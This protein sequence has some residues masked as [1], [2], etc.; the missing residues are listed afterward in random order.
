MSARR[1]YSVPIRRRVDEIIKRID[2]GIW[3]SFIH[4]IRAPTP[5]S[6]KCWA[7][8]YTLSPGPN[9]VVD[10]LALTDQNGFII[11]QV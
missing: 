11:L 4:C 6:H 3:D 1:C 10:S 9:L 2:T 5:R 8:R 7:T